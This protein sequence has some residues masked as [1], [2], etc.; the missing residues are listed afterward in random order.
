MDTEQLTNLTNDWFTDDQI[1]WYPD[2]KSLLFISDRNEI[3]E[4]GILYKPEDHLFNQ[5][6]IYKYNIE[7]GVIKRI[8]NTPYNE[9]YPCISND[10]NFLAFI[11][12]KN[13]INNIYLHRDIQTPFNTNLEPQAITNALTG[14]T[15]LS[16]NGDNT[17]LIFT[18][19]FN[20]GYDIYTFDN[21]IDK[22]E[23]NIQ[24]LPAKWIIQTNEAVLLR[25]DKKGNRKKK[26]P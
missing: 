20:R 10:S 12:D 8:T 17:Q 3:L 13:G 15:R 23:D 2:G 14:I 9:T 19:F 5:T 18:G 7:S 25:N 1:S 24:L 11:A 6:D 26:Y 16:W 4:T 22:I 21:P